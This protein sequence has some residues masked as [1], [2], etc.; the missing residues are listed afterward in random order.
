MI[1]DI[2]TNLIISDTISD[3]DLYATLDRLCLLKGDPLNNAIMLFNVY[4]GLDWIKFKSVNMFEYKK[5]FEISRKNIY[6]TL[7]AILASDVNN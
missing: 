7:K 3:I 2:L 1:P 5:I 4:C 6:E